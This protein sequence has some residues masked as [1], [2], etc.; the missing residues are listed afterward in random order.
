MTGQRTD[1]LF[2]I[3]GRPTAPGDELPDEEYR[4]VTPD[5]FRA[6]AI[7]LLKGRVVE[8]S[9]RADGV[10]VVVVNQSFER[11]WFKDGAVGRRI[12][13]VSPQTPWATIVGVV[14]DVRDFGLDKPAKAAMY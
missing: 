6:L 3:E 7:P 14:G 11:R 12:R 9:D 1:R 5:L 8:G 4:I 13:M 10:P 2:E